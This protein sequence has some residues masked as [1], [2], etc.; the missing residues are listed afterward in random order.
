V[1]ADI[2]A[3][4]FVGTPSKLQDE[5][6]QANTLSKTLSHV[7]L[8]LSNILLSVSQLYAKIKADPETLRWAKRRAIDQAEAHQAED[9]LA[10][11]AALLFEHQKQQ[12]EEKQLAE[13]EQEEQKAAEK[14]VSPK[15]QRRTKRR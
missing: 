13:Q 15:R 5:L 10:V 9:D 7:L 4:T 8:N 2:I 1:D 14:Q 6:D 11:D 3:E 12:D